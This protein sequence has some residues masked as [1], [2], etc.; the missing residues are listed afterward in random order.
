MNR[1]IRRALRDVRVARA[2]W[3]QNRATVRAFVRCVSGRAGA[4][5]LLAARPTVWHAGD[6][7]GELLGRP[8]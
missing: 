1:R 2:L 6:V 4:I 8:T 7:V 3:L 5:A